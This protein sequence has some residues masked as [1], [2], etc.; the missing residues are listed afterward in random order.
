MNENDEVVIKASFCD[1]LYPGYMDP[2]FKRAEEFGARHP[3]YRVEVSGHDFRTMPQVVAEAAARGEAPDIAGYFYT[4]TQFARDTRDAAGA[5]LFTSVEREVAGRMEILG[6]RV[7]LDDIVPAARNYFGYGRELVSVPLTASTVVL[8]ANAELLEKAGVASLPRTWGEL[9][10][11][12]VAVAESTGGAVKGATWPNHGWLFQEAVGQQG[13]LLVDHDNGR[14]GRAE[15][16]HLTSPELMAYV[17]WWQRLHADGHYLYTGKTGDWM[18]SFDAFVE[19]RAAFLITTSVEVDRATS[20]ARDAGFTTVAGSL[21]HN[22][23]APHAG[24][25]IGGDSLWLA[26][27]LSQAKKDCAL[28]FIQ[29]LLR[30][31][32]AATWHRANGRIPLTRPAITLLESEGWFTEHPNARVATEQ[33]DQADGSPAALG[34]LAGAF[35]SIQY[36]TTEAMHD[37]LVEGADPDARFERADVEAQENLTEYNADCTGTGARTPRNLTVAW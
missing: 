13:G 22:E 19:Q 20:T 31:E 5:P 7:V 21:P 8:L 26:A 23:N 33:L 24:T 27:G 2:L 4:S 34:M 16:A 25:S 3:G 10:A 14:S 18:G 32:N 11:A 9:E 12:C 17:K 30:P 37:V 1:Y 28:A 29:F 35:A 15:K 6:E 36:G